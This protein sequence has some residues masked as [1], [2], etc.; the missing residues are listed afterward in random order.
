AYEGVEPP[1]M[2]LTTTKNFGE[3]ISLSIR[4]AEADKADVWIDLN[5]D[6]IKDPGEDDILFDGYKDYTLG[7]QTVTIYG[8]ANTMDCLDNSLTTLDV[9][10]NTALQFLYCSSNSLSTL[11]VTNNTALLGLHCSE[12]SLTE[13]DVSNNTEL[14][15]LYCSENSLT[16]LDVT[17]NT[18]LLVIDCSANQI[19]GE[20]MEIL[21]NS[22]FNRKNT[23]EG[24]FRVH[25]STTPNNVITKAQVAK[26]KAKN[27]RVV[28]DQ[29]ND[30]EGI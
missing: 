14:L 23:T 16:E 11:D 19:E 7:A 22:L 3:T 28:D 24:Y 5:N 30:Y 2:T 8:K 9:S 27:W 10:Y 17:N 15:S 26:A 18:E 29:N 1:K 25:S 21:V 6:G 4:A 12:N 20:K 13:L